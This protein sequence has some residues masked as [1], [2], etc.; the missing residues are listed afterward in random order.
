MTNQEKANQGFLEQVKREW[1]LLLLILA[2]FLF[3][4]YVFPQLPEQVPSHWNIHG[5]IDGW[6]TKNFAVWFF[7]LLN[8]GLYL[9]MLFLPNLDP[10]KENY[11][12]FAGA[13]RLIRIILLIF[14]A[15]LY[16]VTL[17]VAL[18]YPLK[19][20]FIVKALVAVL[21]LLIG[22]YMGKFQHNYFV[23]IKTP[24][25]LASEEVWRQTHRLAGPIW[26]TGGVFG[27]ILSFFQTPLAG[28]LTF[29]VYILIALIPVVYS[30]F[31]FRKVK[32]D[33]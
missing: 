18:G 22:N 13:Y 12:R 31:A 26:V 32:K 10:R 21:F 2:T 15:V 8:L 27:L 24:W 19:V 3:G 11:V 25:T 4:L 23:G 33:N 6:T 9:L 5:E 30:Y 28:I 16:M 14:L 17:L 7:P 20:D 29:T 1:Y